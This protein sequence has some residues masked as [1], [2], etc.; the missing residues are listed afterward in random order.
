MESRSRF[1]VVANL[2]LLLTSVGA[3]MAPA[4]GPFPNPG[5]PGQG[6]V[7]GAPPNP[8]NV[9]PGGGNNIPGVASAPG[10]GGLPMPPPS[11]TVT[12]PGATVTT[13]TT[14]PSPKTSPSPPSPTSPP[15]TSAPAPPTVVAFITTLSLDS[16]NTFNTFKP[17]GV[18]TY[19]QLWC[20]H[21]VGSTGASCSA[22]ATAGSVNIDTVLTFPP[23]Q[24]AASAATSLTNT[25]QAIAANPSNTSL[26]G[27]LIPAGVNTTAFGFLGVSGIQTET[28]SLGPVGSPYRAPAMA[29]G[30]PPTTAPLPPITFSFVVRLSLATPADFTPALQDQ[31]CRR[32]LANTGAGASCNIRSVTAGSVVVITDMTYSANDTA[33]EGAL[34]SRLQAIQANPNLASSFFGNDF[35]TIEVLSIGTAAVPPSPPPP[36]KHHLSGGKIAGAVIGSVAGAAILGGC[37][38]AGYK[39]YHTRRA[40]QPAV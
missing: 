29:P 9:M 37:G 15:V 27:A 1:V 40:Y 14:S 4:P 23:T 38:F 21:L 36:A 32:L 13:P 22:T 33:S 28:L 30:F 3:Q 11:P 12:T 31:W 26:L 39:Y 24:A 17:D 7:N 2:A 18:N 6:L 19:N 8:N 34:T 35:G 16:P 10:P 5:L 20:S 25:L